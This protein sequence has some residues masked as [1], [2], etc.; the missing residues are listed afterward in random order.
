MRHVSLESQ[1][2]LKDMPPQFAK[3]LGLMPLYRTFIDGVRATWADNPAA[4]EYL[5]DKVNAV[6]LRTEQPRGGR[7]RD[8]PTTVFEVML[9]DAMS[10]SEL[11]A[12]RESLKLN[13]ALR[14]ISCDELRIGASK[15]GMLQR[16]PLKNLCAA[17]PAPP[18]A[19]PK[20]PPVSEAEALAVLRRACIVV[21]GEEALPKAAAITGAKVTPAAA[22]SIEYRSARQWYFC[23]ATVSSA[24]AEKELSASAEALR[25][26]CFRLGLPLRK[27]TFRDR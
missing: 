20:K 15:R 7:L 11:N 26:K 12:R 3:T 21:F 19:A 9:S 6:Y 18:T 22:S 4:A 17:P 24:A 14:G 23:N 25:D 2:L 1:T 16:H 13:L 10:R 5:L 27:L 8:V